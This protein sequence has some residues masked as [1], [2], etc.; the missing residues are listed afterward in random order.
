MGAYGLIGGVSERVTKILPRDISVARSLFVARDHFGH[1]RDKG[2]LQV[3]ALRE[4]R[5]SG[6]AAN[7]PRSPVKETVQVPVVTPNPELTRCLARAVPGIF[8]DD[9]RSASDKVSVALAR[10]TTRTPA[11]SSRASATTAVPGQSRR[12]HEVLQAP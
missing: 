3:A 10:D 2:S 12:P 1:S 11:D 9:H 7:G 8:D 5:S 4:T 6:P